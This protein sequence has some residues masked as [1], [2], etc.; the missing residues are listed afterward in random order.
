[1]VPFLGQD[2]TT[3]QALSFNPSMG[4]AYLAIAKM[5]SDSAKNCGS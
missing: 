1:M 5:Y 3:L 2:L 4:R